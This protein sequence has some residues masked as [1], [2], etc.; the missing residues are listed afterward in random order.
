MFKIEIEIIMECKS[1]NIVYKRSN[2]AYVPFEPI[3]NLSKKRPSETKLD[4]VHHFLLRRRCMS[5]LWN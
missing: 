1:S 4:I 5:N 2:N 3:E